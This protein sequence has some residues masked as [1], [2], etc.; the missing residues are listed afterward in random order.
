MSIGQTRIVSYQLNIELT[1][2][3]HAA[4]DQAASR[5]SISRAAHARSII[6]QHFDVADPIRL[7]RSTAIPPEDIATIAALTGAAGKAAGATV[8]LSKNLRTY[9]LA[10]A[11][12]E[13]E[14]VLRDLRT[15]SNSLVA[16]T[17]RLNAQR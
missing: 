15:I 7:R 4:L 8:Q 2:E 9:P 13:A 17:E 12:R 3:L 16:L 14:A 1:P 6:A 5:Q 10:A 11:H